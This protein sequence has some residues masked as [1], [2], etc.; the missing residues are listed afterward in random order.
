MSNA[1]VLTDA[2]LEQVCR[3]LGD[4]ATGSEITAPKGEL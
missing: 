2:Q 1:P 4:C 3:L